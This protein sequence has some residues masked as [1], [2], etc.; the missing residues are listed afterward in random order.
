MRL[1]LLVPCSCLLLAALPLGRRA[2]EP[3]AIE[4]NDNRT[5]AGILAGGT[6]ELRLV[7][8]PGRWHPE[9]EEGPGVLVAALGEE[10]RAPSIPAPLVRVPLGTRIH[11]TIR[12]AFPDSALVV[13]GL[14]PAGD[15]L[16]IPPGE[17]RETGF[18]P[19]ATGT[20]L[21]WATRGTEMPAAR[22]AAE[23][24]QL[25]G[26]VVVDPP[27]G[28]PP[29]RVWVI[30]IWS[31]PG[32]STATPRRPPGSVLA[33]NGKDASLGEKLYELVND[34]QDREFEFLVSGD[35][36]A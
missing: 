14:S 4:A 26:A 17:T 3:P 1:S 16:V 27:E 6:L 30:N 5:P 20:F 2:A 13:H 19:D 34:K 12:N 18:T 28:S 29:D 10:G 35:L 31:D 32:D 11:A 23:G 9:A 36:T 25:G 24:E 8:Q 21:Y 22:G 15:S 7:A 33:I